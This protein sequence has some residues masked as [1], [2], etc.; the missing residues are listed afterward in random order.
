MEFSRGERVR[1]DLDTGEI[2]AAETAQG[3]TLSPPAQAP[4]AFVGD[5]LERTSSA[6]NPP[7]AP[8]FRSN[9]SGF[10]THKKRTPRVSAFK[11]QRNSRNEDTSVPSTVPIQ[12]PALPKDVGRDERHEIDQENKQRLDAMT[13]EEIDQE[14]SELFSSLPPS[15]IQKLLARANLDEASNEGELF[16]ERLPTPSTNQPEAPPEVKTSSPKKV[17]FEVPDTTSTPPVDGQDEEENTPN[18]GEP[19]SATSTIDSERNLQLHQLPSSIHFP[20][21]PQPPDLDPNAPS[22]L[23]DLHEKYFPNLAY[24]PSSLSWMK[25]IDSSDTT[26]P[27]HPSQTALNA[28]E[29][30]FNF[31]GALLAPSK[32]RE[33]PVTEGLH[34]HAE[35]PEAAGYT[36]PEL[37]I[38]A[39]SAVAAQRCMAYQT[40]G[41]IL[42]RLGQGEFGVE[43]KKRA[44]DGP[45]RIAHNPDEE[46]EESIADDEDAGSAMASGLWKCVDEGRVIETLTAEAAKERG[47]RTAKTYA[48]EALWNW[49][50][51][52][53]RTRQAI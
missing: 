6:T 16:P 19:E 15:L 5:I 28:D 21:P 33:I 40:L 45:M 49:R 31:K 50:R 1:F 47:H 2:N 44:P 39:R 12:K 22:F 17:S 29:L 41:R 48:E 37:S 52:G 3:S 32:A 35:A 9:T 13:E 53:G 34:H 8:T 25:P 51:G 27:Y 23:D 26:S 14:R 10:P 20:K 11:Q 18:K 7:I 38:L 30:R 43:K 42:Y 36:L 24:D 4:A 46:D